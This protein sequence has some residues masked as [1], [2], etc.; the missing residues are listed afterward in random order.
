MHRIKNKMTKLHRNF[1]YTVIITCIPPPSQNKVAYL[2]L[3]SRA[4]YLITDYYIYRLIG[5]F[6]VKQKFKRN[7][8]M[9]FG[10]IDMFSDSYIYIGL[11]WRMLR[12]WGQWTIL[13]WLRYTDQYWILNIFRNALSRHK[14]LHTST[15]Y[16][17]LWG[18][19][20]PIGF[21]S[22]IEWY[23]YI[24]QLKSTLKRFFN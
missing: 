16:G 22:G 15:S 7:I 9:K 3:C 4:Y 6:E 18:N 12:C 23:E 8:I 5:K 11:N 1:V 19:A 14:I 24:D 10:E 13:T 2:L 21:F 20:G 17:R